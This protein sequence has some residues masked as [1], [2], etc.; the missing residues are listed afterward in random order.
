MNQ[1]S[2]EHEEWAKA[3]SEERQGSRSTSVTRLKTIGLVVVA[4]VIGWFLYRHVLGTLAIAPAI[5]LVALALRWDRVRTDPET[6][7][8]VI[9][10]ALYKWS[11]GKTFRAQARQAF[12]SLFLHGR[13]FPKLFLYGYLWWGA[14]VAG[15]E[16]ASLDDLMEKNLEG[17]LQ[18]LPDLKRLGEDRTYAEGFFR[19]AVLWRFVPLVTIDVLYH[20]LLIVAMPH[21]TAWCIL[22]AILTGILAWPIARAGALGDLDHYMRSYQ[23]LHNYF[24]GIQNERR[25]SVMTA[26]GLS[27]A[28]RENA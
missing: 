16:R 4:V 1:V 2:K 3:R 26:E 11:Y 10:G 6:G 17:F 8:G 25:K 5:G 9:A 23:L 13:M 21:L 24:A 12:K 27:E 14:P 15:T 28:I 19:R 7:N 20:L 22:A 18:D